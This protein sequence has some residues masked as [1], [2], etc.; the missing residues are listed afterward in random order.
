[1]TPYDVDMLLQNKGII[2]NRGK[3]KAAITNAQ[4]FVQLQQE[5]GSFSDFM[6]SYTAGKAHSKR[7]PANQRTS[8]NDQTGYSNEF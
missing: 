1:M 8:A 4:L 6:W 5:V 7:L 2:R 3:I